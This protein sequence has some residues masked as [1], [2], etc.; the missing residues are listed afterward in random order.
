MSLAPTTTL[1]A[2]VAALRPGQTVT[3]TFTTRTVTAVLR[4][5]SS[6]A[7]RA[8]DPGL[9]F[10]DTRLGEIVRDWDGSPGPR[11]TSVTVVSEPDDPDLFQRV[12][13]LVR[14][15]EHAHAE[16]ETCPRSQMD[17]LGERVELAKLAVLAEIGRQS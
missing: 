17:R 3:V 6:R 13:D 10:L 15:W 7:L 11:V 16:Y 1:A 9:L 12:V 5:P 4:R 2:T 8:V 14:E